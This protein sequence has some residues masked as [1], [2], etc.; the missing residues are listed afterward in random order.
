M[1]GELW[2]WV[3][4][5][6]SRLQ[7][8]PVQRVSAWGREKAQTIDVGIGAWLEC[9]PGWLS[10]GR[11]RWKPVWSQGRRRRVPGTWVCSRPREV[12]PEL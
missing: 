5:C 9:E 6:D 4:G 12:F 1:P 11:V 3:V 8:A 2:V 7:E 10:L